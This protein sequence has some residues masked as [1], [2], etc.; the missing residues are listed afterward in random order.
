MCVILM[1]EKE[2]VEVFISK[3]EMTSPNFGFMSGIWLKYFE[4]F[5]GLFCRVNPVSPIIRG[6]SNIQLV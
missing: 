1:R 6:F 3:T 5:L 2:G 4:E